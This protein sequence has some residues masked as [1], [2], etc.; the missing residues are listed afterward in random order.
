MNNEIGNYDESFFNLKITIK[1]KTILAFT[2]NKSD[3]VSS[4]ERLCSASEWVD[5]SDLSEEG[6]PTHWWNTTYTE[7]ILGVERVIFEP[8]NVPYKTILS[9]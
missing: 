9:E 3:C 5:V 6:E 7:L 4:N 1:N 8:Y 2:E